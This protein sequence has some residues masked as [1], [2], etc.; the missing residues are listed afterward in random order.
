MVMAR[1][2]RS[3]FPVVDGH[4]LLDEPGFWPAHVA[5]MT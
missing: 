1:H 3:S 2:W 5:D 4:S